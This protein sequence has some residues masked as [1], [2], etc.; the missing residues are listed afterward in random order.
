MQSLPLLQAKDLQI[1]Q[2]LLCQGV[3]CCS[4]CWRCLIHKWVCSLSGFWVQDVA[5]KVFLDQHVQM[6]AIEEFKAEVAIMRRLRHPNVVLFMG[7]VTKPPNL[8]IITEFCP[9]GS[10]YRLLHRP[11]RELDEKRRIRMALDVVSE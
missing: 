5:V 9:R 2:F 7:A 11:N 1:V 6:E 4:Y 8:S 10:L 3:S